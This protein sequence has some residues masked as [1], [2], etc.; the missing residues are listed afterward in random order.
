MS[1]NSQWF[2][3]LD[4]LHR[5]VFFLSNHLFIFSPL[6]SLP[7]LQVAYQD[8]TDPGRVVEHGNKNKNSWNPQLNGNGGRGVQNAT[9]G[10]NDMTNVNEVHSIIFQKG[11]CSIADHH[12]PCTSVLLLEMV[13]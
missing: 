4:G 12:C 7:S 3:G 11:K 1:D 13:W 10:A 5:P 2:P 6:C 9:I 8:F